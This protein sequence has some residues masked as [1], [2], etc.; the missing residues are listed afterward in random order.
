[1]I[2]RH[3]FLVLFM[4][5]P[6]WSNA[7]YCAEQDRSTI[8]ITDL[9]GQRFT[10]N[11]YQKGKP[12]YLKFWATW[13]QPC[14]QQ[15]P[16]LQQVYEQYGDKIQIIAVNLGIND[17]LAAI[18]RT[19]KEFSL[20]LPM[21]IDTSGQLAQAFKL[22]G[23]PYHILLD[24]DA[25]IVH[26]GHEASAE[27]DEKLRL[28]STHGQEKL[29]VI[30]LETHTI[31]SGIS[32][33]G[34]NQPS[35]LFFVSSWC[36]WYLKE[37][38]PAMSST[39]IRAQKTVNDLYTRY[40]QWQWNGV[41]SRLWTT[42]KELEQYRHRYNIK[43]PLSIDETNQ[44]FLDYG[45]KQLPTLILMNKGKQIARI[46]QF[47]QPDKIIKILNSVDLTSQQSADGH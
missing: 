17:D 20:T 36:D 3:L 33:A 13:C 43:H 9:S 39:C 2:F 16:H 23:T 42:Q 40:P 12:V 25:N 4:L 38:R 41:V 27:L 45:V 11:D 19:K 26:Q 22:I 44:M 30:A 1:M 28:L 31:A 32:K 14:R 35:A 15:M 47:D 24:R 10:L 7:A 18:E 21:A 5:S 46:S 6:P 37:S 29:P 34:Q 8:K